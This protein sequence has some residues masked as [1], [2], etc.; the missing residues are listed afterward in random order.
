MSGFI[1]DLDGV[2]VD[3]AKFHFEAWRELARDLGFDMDETFNETLK[4][5][6]RMESLEKILQKGNIDAS[7]DQKLSWAEQKN[8]SYLA[9]VQKMTKADVL[10]GVLAFLE[11]SKQLKIPMAVG[12]AS[13]NAV[14]ILTLT[15][16]K[17]Y[18][19]VIIDGNQIS[20]GKP[21]PEVFLLAAKT[22][23]LS[24]ALCVVFEDA[25][26]GIEAALAAG[27]YAVGVG[28]LEKADEMISG[29]EGQDPEQ[30]ILDPL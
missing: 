1:F 26:A 4:G 13:K 6:S 14:A 30:F 17:D 3:T 16:I 5:V 27:M 18:F 20:K 12:S 10:P 29:F 9:R 28:D 7:S 21:D 25:E 11:K 19:Q 23:Q 2:L 24:P 15:E 22:L 8:Q